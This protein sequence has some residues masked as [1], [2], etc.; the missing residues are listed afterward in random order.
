[1]T[2]TIGPL[3]IQGLQA[4]ESLLNAWDQLYFSHAEGEESGF[5][6]RLSN[7]IRHNSHA[8]KESHQTSET[9]TQQQQQNQPPQPIY[10]TSLYRSGGRGVWKFKTELKG[11]NRKTGQVQFLSRWSTPTQ[12]L[13]VPRGFGGVWFTFEQGE[14]VRRAS[15]AASEA[16]KKKK[17]G[18]VKF[19]TDNNVVI[20]DV[21][22]GSESNSR[23]S[24]TS[25][26]KVFIPILDYSLTIISSNGLI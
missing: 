26:Y 23:K 16:A 15:L 19:N 13:P 11:S 7:Q 24:V 9:P 3:E 20:N 14:Q 12:H 17:K 2:S 22:E 18:G 5:R 6:P 4:V 10:T 8:V 1:M 25:A 21:L